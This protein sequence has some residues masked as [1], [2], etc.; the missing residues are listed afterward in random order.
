M[1]EKSTNKD[2]RKERIRNLI[3]ETSGQHTVS[4]IFGKSDLSR[5]MNEPDPE[6]MW[7]ENRKI[8]ED[9]NRERPR[10]VSGLLRRIVVCILIFGLVWGIFTVQNPWTL[11]AQDF[12]AD[13][14]S[15]EMDFEAARVWY[16]QYFKGA[17]AFIPIFGREDEA[18]QKAVVLHGLS[19]P[20]S[21]SIV[22]PFATSLKGVEIMPAVDSSDNVMVKSVDMGRVLS[23]SRE[24][25]GGIRIRIRHTE[26]ITA[27]YGHLNGTKLEVDDW[28]QSGDTVG[29]LLQQEST[30][31]P[32]LF[33]AVMR[34]TT[35]V[36]PTEV[37]SFD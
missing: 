16:E 28:V 17:P 27:E 5:E 34:D 36:D 14:L 29:W 23:V 19:A 33:F 11:K 10:F 35:Y 8:W 1:D 13:S 15:N 30:S 26:N 9:G 4:S 20:V 31:L 37:I 22:Q 18:A 25:E 6:V 12:I 7:K 2:R 3:D 32:T 21:G 24:L